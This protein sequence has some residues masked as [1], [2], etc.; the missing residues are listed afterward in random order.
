MASS[1]HKFDELIHTNGLLGSTFPMWIWRLNR[2]SRYDNSWACIINAGNEDTHQKKIVIFSHAFP[3]SIFS[4]FALSSSHT[5]IHVRRL[6]R[7]HVYTQK[8]I[9]FIFD[10]P[11]FDFISTVRNFNFLFAIYNIIALA[12]QSKTIRNK[13][14]FFI[15]EQQSSH[16]P[17][18]AKI[19]FRLFF[20]HRMLLLLLLAS[21]SRNVQ[22]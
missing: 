20:T 13:W 7:T 2:K 1:I 21:H 22:F 17:Y 19:L 16:N 8:S 5:R 9:L 10:T 12:T 3:T 18:K 15:F 11:I 6:L 14:F 4:D